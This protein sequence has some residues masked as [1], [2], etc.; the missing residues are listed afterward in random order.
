MLLMLMALTGELPAAERSI[1]HQCAGLEAYEIRGT[2]GVDW[3]WGT[4]RAKARDVTI[5]F[6]AGSMVEE[7]V[8]ATRPPGFRTFK[9]EK[10][11]RVVMRSGFN[12]RRNQM[13]VTLLGA[14]ISRRLNLI[15]RAENRT[16]LLAIARV[17]AT[18]RC[19]P[20]AI[21]KRW[22]MRR[23]H[24]SPNAPQSGHLCSRE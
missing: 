19:A 9:A 14:P 24:R 13:E 15:G 10:L 8:P 20:V 2:H 17:L 18:A 6:S 4:I 22:L 23:R 12:V 1:T 11:G 16:E 7:L 21:R 5:G 3:T